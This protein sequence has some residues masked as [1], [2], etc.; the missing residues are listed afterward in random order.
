MNLIKKFPI[1]TLVDVTSKVVDINERHR[2]KEPPIF[3]GTKVVQDL[4]VGWKAKNANNSYSNIT[5]INT[6]EGTVKEV[7]LSSG[8]SFFIDSNS[9]IEPG[10]TF[11]EFDGIITSTVTSVNTVEESKTLYELEVDGDGSLVINN[12]CLP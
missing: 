5:A 4:K 10:E 7:K 3:V 11:T 6:S 9:T 1:A 2:S 12:I 8:N